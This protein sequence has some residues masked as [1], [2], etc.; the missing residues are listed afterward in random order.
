MGARLFETKAEA[1][2]TLKAQTTPAQRKNYHIVKVVR[3][4]I[5]P[6]PGRR[7]YIG[8]TR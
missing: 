3:Y 6:R 7:A 2:R 8:I 5:E 1:T 4:T